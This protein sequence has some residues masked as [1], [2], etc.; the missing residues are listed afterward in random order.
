MI[1]PQ[2]S[3]C[4]PLGTLRQLLTNT[5]VLLV[6]AVTVG[7]QERIE[8]L[9]QAISQLDDFS[10]RVAETLK[11]KVSRLASEK[12]SMRAHQHKGRVYAAPVLEW[13][14]TNQDAG[15]GLCNLSD[16]IEHA[17]NDTGGWEKHLA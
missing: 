3:R 8:A 12:L 7:D 5:E 17:G 2:N 16:H 15:A 14:V 4:V 9:T 1:A 13:V 11:R 6:E 10:S